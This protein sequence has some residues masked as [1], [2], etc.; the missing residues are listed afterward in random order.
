M[1]SFVAG[2][3]LETGVG[4][5]V[6]HTEVRTVEVTRIAAGGRRTVAAV[7]QTV[8]VAEVSRIVAVEKRT[9]AEGSS[10]AAAEFVAGSLS[11]WG[12]SS[13]AAA[14]VA[15]APSDLLEPTS[16]PVVAM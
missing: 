16:V 1:V 7:S 10:V 4:R 12:S 5:L 11:D 13:V 8:V 6:E 2:E 3:I 15:V 14:A 9:P